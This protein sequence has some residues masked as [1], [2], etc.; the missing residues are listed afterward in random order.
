M[1]KSSQ[2]VGDGRQRTANELVDGYGKAIRE[3][4]KD[5]RRAEKEIV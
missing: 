1:S 3:S 5:S 2:E 4:V